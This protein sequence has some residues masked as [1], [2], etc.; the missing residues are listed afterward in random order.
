[1][2]LS[3]TATVNNCSPRL[4]LVCA[5]VVLLPTTLPTAVSRYACVRY[6]RNVSC[7]CCI[8]YAPNLCLFV[9]VS[10]SYEFE[11]DGGDIYF[12]ISFISAGE[13]AVAEEVIKVDRM[14]SDEEPIR[15]RF[16]AP[17][18]GVIVFKWNNEYSWFASKSLSY[19]IEMAQ[20]CMCVYVVAGTVDTA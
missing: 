9:L 18:E 13:S 8:W 12:G 20:V 2:L 11:T 7:S 15:G 6:V 1:V 16:K 10:V 17:S 5:A 19:V 4:G 3:I 14:P